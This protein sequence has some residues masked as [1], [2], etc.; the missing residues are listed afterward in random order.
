MIDKL[1]YKIILGFAAIYIIWGS[2]Y[3]AIRIGVE[4]IPP[5]FMASVRFTVAG[6][7]FYLYGRIKKAE[8]PKTKH[9]ITTSIVGILLLVGGNGLVSWAE[10]VVPSGLT[11]LL[12]AMV[13]LWIVLFDAIHPKG[14]RP[15]LTAIGGLLLGFI[16]VAALINP[17]NI[18]GLA[19]IDYF[20]AVLIIF[21]SIF[22]A[23]GSIYAK[24]AEMPKSM[25]VASGMQMIVA[26][27][28]LLILSSL[29]G[30]LNQ[31]TFESITYKAWMSLLYL[32]TFGSVGY[33]AYIWLLQVTEPSKV[34]TYAYVNPIIALIL[35]N[36]IAS[37]RISFWTIGCSAF[38]LIAVF[39]IVS[40][41]KKV[42][43]RNSN[44]KE[45]HENLH[46]K[47]KL[48]GII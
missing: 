46:P 47:T 24:H 23:A 40:S 3:L 42:L 32:I 20:G 12:I 8:K 13:P 18:G 16:G 26:G 31:F 6:I 21:A 15:T 19:E 28:V 22:W 1:K 4:T 48:K 30:E 25:I 9:W 2:T 34:A 27:V 14:T 29:T 11:A 44:K 5:F 45:E 41:K 7:L 37:E 39:I 35:G 38:I 43:K 33:G 10:V 36:L 17:T